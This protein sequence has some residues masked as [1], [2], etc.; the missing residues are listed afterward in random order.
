MIDDG[1]RL[2][3]DSPYEMHDGKVVALRLTSFREK[4]LT[5]RLQLM[6]HATGLEVFHRPGIHSDRAED[7]RLPDLGV[8]TRLPPDPASCTSLPG[9]AFS[10]VVEVVAEGEEPAE[11]MSWYAER[12]IPV[13]WIVVMP[14]GDDSQVIV[15]FH[16]RVL[17]GGRPQYELRD[18]RRL[19]EI[20]N[21]LSSWHIGPVTSGRM[22]SILMGVG[23]MTEGED[24]MTELAI[25]PPVEEADDGVF[26]DEELLEE[27]R[28]QIQASSPTAA[29]NEALRRL[30]ETERGKRRAA[31]EKLRQ[32]VENGEITFREL[33][34]A[35]E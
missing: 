29:M 11:R 24:S 28:R 8:V 14:R 19:A 30:V 27:A 12:G 35:D 32:M 31:G 7:W 16:R 2:G 1:D 23:G 25:R 17:R 34:E 5:A 26:L 15:E 10:L 6:L 22:T 20:E 13:C 9:D 21:D 18:R 3:P 33:G 4:A